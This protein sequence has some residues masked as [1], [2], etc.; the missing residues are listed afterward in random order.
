MVRNNTAVLCAERYCAYLVPVGESMRCLSSRMLCI[1]LLTGLAASSTAQQPSRARPQDVASIDAIITA[2]YAAISHPAEKPADLQR[3]QSL[4]QPGAQ[5][6]NVSDQNGKPAM[7]AGAIEQITKMLQST[8]HPERAHFEKEIARRTARFGNVAHVWS[9]YQSTNTEQ[10]R[11]TY[12]RGINSI[13]L[14]YD[15]GRWW[16]VSAQWTNET[17]A[18]P[19]PPQYLKGKE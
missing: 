9:T 15:G 11:R 4:F 10:K 14:V 7:R 8:Q 17:K 5:L 16:I 18:R 3:F 19:I 13:S 1:L 12:V 2:S 6:F